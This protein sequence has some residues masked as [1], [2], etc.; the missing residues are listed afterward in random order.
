LAAVPYEGDLNELVGSYVGPARGHPL[1]LE[2]VRD[3]EDLVFTPLGTTNEI[4]PVHLE[5]LTW[6]AGNTRLWFLR[7]KGAVVGLRM[8]QGSGHYV[9]RRVKGSTSR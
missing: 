4:R 3:G 1:T 6:G 2:V 5:G 9:L 7:E 8:D